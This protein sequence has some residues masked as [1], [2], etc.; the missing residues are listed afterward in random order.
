MK[1]PLP[2][3]LI[4]PNDALHTFGDAQ[5]NILKGHG[6]T[7]ST[8]LFV[9]FTDLAKTRAWLGNLLALAPGQ[10]GVVSTAQQ[11]HDRAAFQK[12][13]K[14]SASLTGQVVPPAVDAGP[15]VS[16]LF[17]ALGLRWLGAALPAEAADQVPGAPAST[18]FAQGM[19]DVT[20]RGL[21]DPTPGKWDAGWFEKNG[22]PT[23]VHA[24]LLLA[25]TRLPDLDKAVGKAETALALAGATVRRK[26][27]GKRLFEGTG[28]A[29]HDIEHFGYADGVSQP[30]YLT[31]DHN[32]ATPHERDLALGADELVLLPD[33]LSPTPAKAWG[34]FLVFRKLQQD[35]NAFNHDE[36][37]QLPARLKL[38]QPHTED[39]KSFAGAMVVGRFENGTPL[40][41]HGRREDNNGQPDFTNDF[42]YADD[43]AG[44]KCPF[45]AHVRKMNPRG[46]TNDPH[47]L[48]HRITR[49]GV[50]YGT[51]AA[52]ERG[53][54]AGL[55]FICY[56]RNIG[57]QFEFLQKSWAN[58]AQFLRPLAQP[59]PATG[60]DPVIGQGT[61][62][63][64]TFPT[65]WN[66]PPT[67]Q[68]SF[69]EHVHLKGGE[70]FYA[71]SI[72]GLAALANVSMPVLPKLL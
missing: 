23:A 70:Y 57:Q 53:E 25:S 15:F 33:T 3:A 21:H 61:R 65:A 26:E 54:P 49:R 17:T 58:N 71:P 39:T 30:L 12:A 29:K 51:R 67:A 72:S 64:L 22:Q 16:V 60:L 66:W 43:A 59:G 18:A 19:R 42:T 9:E 20:G 5:G 7:H 44:L 31:D 11:L 48:K 69:G 27:E 46:E 38:Q 4:S 45:H 6:R 13:T 1:T 2:K 34:S 24:L 37:D 52:A 47:E 62:H 8:F 28:P 63:Q 55:L 36:D 10:G 41:L 68:A 40:T 32:P 56:Q 14:T 35:V 50:P